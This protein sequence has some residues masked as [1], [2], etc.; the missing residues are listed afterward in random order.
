MAILNLVIVPS[1]V[2]ESGKHKVRI[3]VAHRGQTKYIVTD[4]VVDN[5]E[6]LR[7]GIIVNHPRAKELNLRL[8]KLFNDYMDNLY[9]IQYPDGLTCEQV[10]SMI[11]QKQ[12]FNSMTFLSLIDFIIKQKK[13]RT[14]NNTF[15]AYEWTRKQW[16][17]NI[18][19]M[20]LQAITPYHVEHFKNV[21]IKQKLSPA[22]VSIA[23]M[24]TKAI[25]NY[26]EKNQI[27]KWDI[28]P[29]INTKIPNY[30]PRICNLTVEELKR[31]RDSK[32][33]SAKTN[34]VRDIFMLSFYLGG[35]NACDMLD[36]R[37]DLSN[38]Y[39]TYLRKKTKDRKSGESETII[40]ITD[41]AR[42][43]IKKYIKNNGKLSFFGLDGK[44]TKRLSSILHFHLGKIKVEADIK[45]RLIYYSARKTFAQIAYDN[46]VQEST[47]EYLLGETMK[48]NRP[49]YSYFRVMLSHADEAMKKIM[50]AIR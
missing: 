36:L 46:G 34:T 32:F 33:I 23:L 39:I 42:L 22:S 29:F 25:F 16:A 6:Q 11:V 2:L 50:D 41:E 13:E 21:L 1:K 35:I 26:A 14:D 19:D 17:D 9:S 18:G 37:I 49:I 31:I 47:I 5:P 44:N 3:S 24:Y 10:K 48:T 15:R 12:T 7:N 30:S 45:S 27:A 28:H 40:P 4:V 43:I 38:Q 20:P 8:R